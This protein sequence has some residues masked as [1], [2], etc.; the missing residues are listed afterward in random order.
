[1]P[2]DSRGQGGMTG[3]RRDEPENW[4]GSEQSGPFSISKGSVL[5]PRLRKRQRN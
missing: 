4:D 2:P 3:H 5:K 1:M